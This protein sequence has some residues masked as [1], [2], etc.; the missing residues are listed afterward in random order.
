VDVV[1][2]RFRT[3]HIYYVVHTQY[4]GVRLKNTLYI[5]LCSII[6][7]LDSRATIQRNYGRRN[8]ALYL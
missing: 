2:T 4:G 3:R 6:I 5:G 8:Y 7:E 1:L